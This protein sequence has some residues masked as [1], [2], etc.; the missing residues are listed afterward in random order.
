MEEG[1]AALESALGAAFGEAPVA[2]PVK[3]PAAPV[4]KAPLAPVEAEAEEGLLDA[5]AED[6]PADLLGQDP[7]P[8]PE[9]KPEVAEPSFEIELDGKPEV[10]TGSERV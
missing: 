9:A 10:I 4:A 3:A 7:E 8:E 1:N 2:P 5:P 6:D